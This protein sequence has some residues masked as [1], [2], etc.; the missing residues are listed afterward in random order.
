MPSYGYNH[1]MSNIKQLDARIREQANSKRSSDLHDKDPEQ[2]NETIAET[3]AASEDE[4]D[5]SHSGKRGI[6]LL[7]NLLTTGTLFGGFYAI[8]SGLA[9]QYEVA[10]VAIFAAMFFDGLDGR[11]ARLTNTQS[12]FGV[13]YDSLSDMVAFGVAPAVLVYTWVLESLGTLGWSISF[14][15]VSCAALRLARFNVRTANQDKRYFSGLASPA[16]AALVASMIWCGA[17]LDVSWFSALI[18]AVLT[19]AAGLL[20]VSNIKY[21]SFKDISFAHKVPFAVVLGLCLVIAVIMVDPPRVLLFLAVFYAF[22]A[23][24][25]T[26][27]RGARKL[28]ISNL[29]QKIKSHR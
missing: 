16:A 12:E 26:L 14:I 25:L 28:S 8:L 15:Y 6:Y 4:E 27:F 21:L 9:G 2:L 19:S 20:M 5:Q 17:A 11:V 7:P 18:V 10:A 24:L 22:Y 1:Q 29:V 3:I 23:P 13:E